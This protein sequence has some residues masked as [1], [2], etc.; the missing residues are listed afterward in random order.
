LKK[1]TKAAIVAEFY[2]YGTKNRTS[3]IRTS[4]DRTSGGPPVHDTHHG[5]FQRNS[6]HMYKRPN[7]LDFLNNWLLL[8]HRRTKPKN[9]PI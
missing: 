1:Q 9:K 4:G 5:M 7:I 6:A 8:G 3:G 2:T